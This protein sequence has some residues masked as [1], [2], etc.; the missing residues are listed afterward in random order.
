[1]LKVLSCDEG[2]Q[3]NHHLCPTIVTGTL[4]CRRFRLSNAT[5]RVLTHGCLQ[6][7]HDTLY[8]E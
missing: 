4:C 3:L 2:I 8:K 1:M 5:L 7:S 6:R